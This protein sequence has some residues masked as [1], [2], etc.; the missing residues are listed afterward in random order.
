M[1]RGAGTLRLV[2]GYTLRE[3]SKR[4]RSFSI[5][6]LTVLLTVAFLSLIQNIVDRASI[7]FLKF[8]EDS[9]GQWDLLLTPS[10]RSSSSATV[11]LNYTSINASLAP[12]TMVEGGAPRWILPALISKQNASQ[13]PIYVMIFDRQLEIDVGLAPAWPY[14]DLADGEISV[15]DTLLQKMKVRPNVGDKVTLTISLSDVLESVLTSSST[16]AN[17]TSSNTTSTTN[18]NPLA[19]L[20]PEN[21]FTLSNTTVLLLPTASQNLISQNFPKDANGNYNIT[22]V[23][24][25]IESSYGKYP[26]AIGNI[27]VMS[28]RAAQGI[29]DG[30]LNGTS[31]DPSVQLASLLLNSSGSGLA[32]YTLDLK[33]YAM[34]VIAVLKDRYRIYAQ[35]DNPRKADMVRFSNQVGSNL[36]MGAS[37]DYTAVVLTALEATSFMQIFLGE[38]LFTVIVV[39]IILAVLLIFSLLLADVEEKTFE[40]GMLRS[41][42][43][44]QNALIE[45]LFFQSFFF[46]IPG[47]L[48]GLVISFVAFFPIAYAMSQFAKIPMD[49]SFSTASLIL[50]ICAGIILPILGMILPTQ[51]ALGRSLRDALDVFHSTIN[52]VSVR[53]EKLEKMGLSYFEIIVALVLIVLGFLVYYIVPLS[54]V[55]QDLRLFF[56]IM[57]VILLAMLL[58]AILLGQVLQSWLE[59]LLAQVIVGMVRPKLLHIVKKNLIAHRRRNS[60]TALIVTLCLAYII[61]ASTM[62]TLQS[63]AL[64]ELIEWQYGADI[65]VTAPRWSDPLPEQ[66]LRTFFAQLRGTP[67]ESVVEGFTTTT[68]DIGTFYGLNWQS[69]SPV[70]GLVSQSVNIYGLESNFLSGSYQKYYIPSHVD[71]SVG[72]MP[73]LDSDCKKLDV[74]RA[75]DYEVDPGRYASTSPAISSKLPVPIGVNKASWSNVQYDS[76]NTRLYHS[77][78]PIM[79]S[80]KLEATSYSDA[81]N[82]FDLTI[83][84]SASKTSG[85]TFYRSY[86]CKPVAGLNKMPGFLAVG[87]SASPMFVSMTSFRR[88]LSDIE[89]NALINTG[90]NGT[91][92]PLQKMLIKTAAHATDQQLGSLANEITNAVNNDKITVTVTREQVR[93][94]TAA[95]TYVMY[96]F[97]LVAIVGLVYCFFVLWLSFTANIRENS[98]E[99]GVL[100][101]IGFTVASV[102]SIYVFESICIILACCIIGTLIGTLVALAVALQF[103]LFTSL[104]FNYTFLVPLY[105]VV[106]CLSFVVAVS[107]SYIPSRPFAKEKIASVLKGR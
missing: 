106:I 49:P 67:V 79:M 29:V 42:G 96:L 55:F 85:T 14:R 48:L 6:L 75:L 5:G 32:N 40:Y 59:T 100:R 102:Q 37:I 107:G 82:L 38:V 34:T 45:L 12:A 70:T 23:V 58:G 86:I 28:L 11:F 73:C 61:F 56:R 66:A 74:V 90:M 9:A 62:F 33:D 92:V 13:N 27:A 57:T 2:V 60:K 103:S 41:L 64:G 68:F 97:Y 20:V 95:S 77:A 104:P 89:Q 17:E 16:N 51:R 8:S 30:Y 98:W 93:G 24:D 4:K 26:S 53:V 99:F 46:S 43:L 87:S 47:I 105:S 78:M 35:A 36:G 81:G 1:W 19:N 15:T 7:L 80:S 22:S 65:V 31:N 69:I 39:L 21:G 72:P 76:N 88:F 63:N 50:G 84:F 94:T 52:E 91:S 3:T 18:T 10:I 44:Q 83:S 101:A 54:F 25:A 71:T